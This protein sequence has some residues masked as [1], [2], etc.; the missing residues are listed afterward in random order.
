MQNGSYGFRHLESVIA[1]TSKDEGS[2]FLAVVAPEFFP[3]DGPMRIPQNLTTVAAFADYVTQIV[4]QKVKQLSR[5][6]FSSK[7]MF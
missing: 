6:V 1:G 5:L 3:M 2:I 4:M 7:S